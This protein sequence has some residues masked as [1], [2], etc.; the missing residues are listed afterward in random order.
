MDKI[1]FASRAEQTSYVI[2]LSGAPVLWVSKLQT[3]IA[4]STTEVEYVTLS[5]SMRDL[6]PMKSL[7]SELIR[8]IGVY[9]NELKVTTKS[10]VFEDN[11]GFMAT[12][13]KMTLRSKHIMVK[14]HF[15]LPIKG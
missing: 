12:S 13:P 8:M 6:L 7:L 5:Q 1:L 2:T 14:Y 9:N 10:T 4:L 3:E 11:N 15:L